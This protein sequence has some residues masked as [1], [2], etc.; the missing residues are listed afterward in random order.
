MKL[1]GVFAAMT[2]LSL[3][4]GSCG[5]N[6]LLRSASADFAPVKVG[7]Q[8]SYSSPSGSLTVSHEVT[9]SGP[10][11]GRDAYTVATRIN[12]A[13]ATTDLWSLSSGALE[14]YDASAGVWTLQ[15]RLPY[16]TGNKWNLPTSNGLV[17]SVQQVEGFDNLTT[18]A[19]KFDACYRLKTKTST[20]DP[21]N[22]VT[23]TAESLLWAAPN[24]G[25]VR[26]A[27]VDAAGV[28]TVTLE[29][30]SYRIPR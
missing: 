6:P 3:G 8:W 23:N 30:S 10:A 22:D 4:L 7:S 1:Y 15:R 17:T 9:A 20:Y 13:A 2:I 18:P 29:L 14:E 28:V 25:D 26:Y 16:V 27:T 21:V 5:Q 12:S 19:G 24:I 11:Q